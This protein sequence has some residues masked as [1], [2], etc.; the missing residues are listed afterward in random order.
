MTVLMALA[1]GVLLLATAEDGPRR[2]ALSGW[3]QAVEREARL[4]AEWLAVSQNQETLD[5]IRMELIEGRRSLREAAS[6][7]FAQLEDRLPMDG[8][9]WKHFQGRSREESILRWAI[10]YTDASLEGES[11]QPEVMRRLHAEL[12]DYLETQSNPSPG[13]GLPDE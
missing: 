8:Q 6:P 3:W 4:H 2:S 9:F 1:C 7:M 12:H 13:T 11:R 5:A 10:N